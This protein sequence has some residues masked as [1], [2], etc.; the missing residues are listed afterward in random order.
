M[1]CEEL[2]AA[3]GSAFLIMGES[4]QFGTF[5]DA[6]FW[7][8][9]APPATDD[10]A[11][12]AME[13][14]VDFDGTSATATILMVEYVPDPEGPPFGD[15]VGE[16]T[17]DVTLTAVGSPEPY[18]FQDKQ[19][20]QVFRVEGTLQSYSV[21]GTL[22]MPNGVA[23]DLSS[24]QA[25]TDVFTQFSNSP[26]SAISR[27]SSFDLNC[28]WE[29]ESGFVSLFAVA[30]EF[31]GFSELFIGDGEDAYIGIPA[32]PF[33]LTTAEFAGDYEIFD[34]E[35]GGDPVGTASASA[36]LTPGERIN[37]RFVSGNTKQHVVGRSYLVDG[38]L[39]IT[40]DGQTTELAMDESS[41]FAADVTITDHQS[42]GKGG[43]G[44]PLPNDLPED[45]EPIDIGD[46]V[47]VRNTAG[48][49]LEP[50]AGCFVF[51]PE[52]GEVEVPL[53]HTAW[54]TFTGTGSPVTIDTAGSEFD[55]VVGVYVDDG[56]GGLTQVGCNDDFESLQAQLT[57]DTELGVTYWLQ[58]GG[59]AGETGRLVLSVQ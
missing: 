18:R 1:L 59:F 3:G 5:A 14:E 32:G 10:P 17:V 35:E 19:G 51:F 29:T 46:T 23:F 56:G 52:E 47:T 48:T 53:G 8:P 40:L 39:T 2:T 44:R 42:P 34:A 25:F 21:E 50:E 54:W 24:C 36:A 57:V 28:S 4:E 27:F 38:S 22:T 30:D 7:P 6:A 9:D 26:A 15:P 16:A 49:D 20:N 11:W 12:I 37:E 41:C 31:G 55:T 43:G 45:A 13:A 58:V 33:T